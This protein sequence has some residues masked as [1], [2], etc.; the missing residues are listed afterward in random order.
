[1][2][3]LQLFFIL[4]SDTI[5]SGAFKGGLEA[6]AVLAKEYPTDAAKM[7]ME[8]AESAGIKSEYGLAFASGFLGTADLK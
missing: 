3:S 2:G 6:V 7:G 8:F 1:M 4:N 5:S